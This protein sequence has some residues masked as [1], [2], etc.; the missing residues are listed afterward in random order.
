MQCGINIAIT[1]CPCNFVNKVCFKKTVTKHS[2]ETLLQFV[3][4]FLKQTL[5][6]RFSFD[7]ATFHKK[8]KQHYVPDMNNFLL[9]SE[10]SHIFVK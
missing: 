5:L 6:E 4:V 2:S 8:E 1:Q 9:Y 3:P 10:K 7:G